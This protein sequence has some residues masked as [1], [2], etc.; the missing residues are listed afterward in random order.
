M[1]QNKDDLMYYLNMDLT[2]IEL[3]FVTM[4]NLSQEFAR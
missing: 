2:W 4:L 3:L 1:I